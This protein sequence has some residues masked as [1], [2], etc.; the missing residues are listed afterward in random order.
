M[1]RHS[2]STNYRWLPTGLAGAGLAAAAL[3]VVQTR[4]VIPSGAYLVEIASSLYSSQ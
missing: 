2:R 1:K 4:Q 3:L